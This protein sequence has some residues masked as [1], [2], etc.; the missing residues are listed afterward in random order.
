MGSLLDLHLFPEKNYLGDFEKKDQSISL[1]D[2]L[3]Y[4]H[5]FLSLCVLIFIGENYC[6]SILGRLSKLYQTRN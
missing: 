2:H 1:G 4:S 3:T 6:W 5:T